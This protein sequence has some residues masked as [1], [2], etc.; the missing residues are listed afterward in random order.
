MVTDDLKIVTTKAIQAIKDNNKED[1]MRALKYL[2]CN[3]DC[4]PD[5][6]EYLFL[7]LQGLL[8]KGGMMKKDI[9]F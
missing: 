3:I 2:F 4:R 6:A 8:Q 1:F 7:K 5:Y 9:G